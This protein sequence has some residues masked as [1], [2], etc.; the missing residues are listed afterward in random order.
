MKKMILVF[1]ILLLVGGIALFWTRPDG[2]PDAYMVDLLEIVGQVGAAKEKIAEYWVQ[3]KS[4]ADVKSHVM[5]P[6]IANKKVIQEVAI[7]DAGEIAVN[8][9]LTPKRADQ[10]FHVGERVPISIIWTPVVIDDKEIMWSCHGSPV[11]YMP[12]TCR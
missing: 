6:D 10:K 2:P 4:F 8:A 1:C 5:L 11:E 9:R 7:S 12:T 3:H